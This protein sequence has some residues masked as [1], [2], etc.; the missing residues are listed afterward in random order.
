MSRIRGRDTKPELLLRHILWKRGLRYR[1]KSKLTGKPDLI[2]PSARVVVF[3]DGCQWHCCPDHW[4]RPKSNTDFW[5]A[6][7]E[8]NRNRDIKVNQLLNDEGWKVLRLWEHQV[9]ADPS[10]AAASVFRAV[11][12][13]RVTIKSN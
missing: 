7:F 12:R 6:K 5:D 10:K 1:L 13:K 8:R 4:A 11:T 9:K 3:V 2:F